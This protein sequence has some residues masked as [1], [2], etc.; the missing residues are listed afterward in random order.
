MF[1]GRYQHTIDPTG[2]LSVRGKCR[3]ALAQYGGAQI[4]APN[5]SCLEVHPLEEWQRIE[6]K[7]REQPIFPPGARELSR[8]YISRAKDVTLDAAGRVLIPPDVREQAGLSKEGTLGGG[9]VAQVEGWERGRFGGYER[10][11]AGRLPA[12]VGG[13]AGLGGWAGA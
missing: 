6:T 11:R 8:L 9:G 13:R 7:L 2:R 4:V 1:R 3:D 10:A 5:D 12:P